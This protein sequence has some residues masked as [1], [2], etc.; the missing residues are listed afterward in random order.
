MMAYAVSTCAGWEHDPEAPSMDALGQP[1][2][3]HCGWSWRAHRE[4]GRPH[5]PSPPPD[6]DDE[7]VARAFADVD[8]E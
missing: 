6:Y 4:H 8:D 2:C 7:T 3:I 5:P 1:R